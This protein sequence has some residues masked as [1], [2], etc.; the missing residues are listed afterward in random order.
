[1]KSCTSQSAG[2]SKGVVT[3]AVYHKY[4]RKRKLQN[5]IMREI[6][7]AEYYT[8]TLHNKSLVYST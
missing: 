5:N 3:V 7:G 1:M 4:N 2:K 6:I 8:A